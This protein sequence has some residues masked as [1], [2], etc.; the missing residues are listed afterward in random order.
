[1]DAQWKTIKLFKQVKDTAGDK[2]SGKCTLLY[3]SWK[4]ALEREVAHIQPLEASQWLD[5]LKARTG[6][7]ALTVVQNACRLSLETS[8]EEALRRAWNTLD[9]Q[10]MTTQKPSQQILS[11]RQTGPVITL[12]DPMELKKFAQACDSALC[13]LECYPQTVS[14][15]NEPATQNLIFGRL[16]TEFDLSGENTG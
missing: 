15:L 14:S 8:P 7:E 3:R 10:F 12:S 4:D 9:E 13:L 2:F 11:E 1:M 6:G 16:G 5:L